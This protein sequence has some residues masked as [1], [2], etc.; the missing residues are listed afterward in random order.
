VT[1]LDPAS[2][3]LLQAIGAV[4]DVTPK[5]QT[6]LEVPGWQQRVVNRAAVVRDGVD[7]V[8]ADPARQE[9]QA[10]RVAAQLRRLAGQGPP[11][12]DQ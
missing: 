9:Q 1:A 3:E 7:V 8:L 11:E 2:R 5:P 10:R 6:H 12:L 4:L